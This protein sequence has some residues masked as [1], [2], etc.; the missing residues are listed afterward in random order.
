MCK[1][2]LINN[3]QKSDLNTL[4]DFASKSHDLDG[5]GAIIRTKSNV[6]EVIKDLDK[7]VFYSELTQRLLQGDVNTLVVH[8]R[9]STNH[10]GIEYAHPFEFR[11]VYLTHNGVVQVPG[12]HNTNTKNDSEALLHHLIKTDFDTAAIQGYFSCFLMTE[13]DTLVLVDDTAPIYTNGRIYSSINMS[14]KVSLFSRVT[15]SLL[16]LDLQGKVISHKP[17]QV[18]K[19]S[20]GHASAHLSLGHTIVNEQPSDEYSPN[21]TDF[22][23]LITDSELQ[24]LIK[25]NDHSIFDTIQDLGYAFGLDLTC[26]DLQEIENVIYDC[27]VD[28]A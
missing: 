15:L 10:D 19:S 14:N 8:H 21:V 13:R 22:F 28:I 20:Y 9:T 6:I 7:G 18:S 23:D 24:K 17:I 26:E 27:Q 25:I 2:I 1:H 4:R 16:S 5:F 12:S 3:F 11:R